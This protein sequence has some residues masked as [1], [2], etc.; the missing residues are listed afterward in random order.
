MRRRR[1]FSQRQSPDPSSV[2]RN[3]AVG[4]IS[5]PGKNRSQSHVHQIDEATTLK[6]FPLTSPL[7]PHPP[8][9]GMRP[10][11]ILLHAILKSNGQKLQPTPS[12]EHGGPSF[13]GS[14][15][16]TLLQEY[17]DQRRGGQSRQR[18]VADTSVCKAVQHQGSRVDPIDLDSEDLSSDSDEIVF[19][20]RNGG[21]TRSDDT[22]L[23]EIDEESSTP[24]SEDRRKTIK[25][26]MDALLARQLQEEDLRS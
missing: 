20:G 15:E 12:A 1:H 7:A 3:D 19:T 4:H 25:S 22:E 18:N 14:M 9:R 8:V 6:L 11:V 17:L 2:I 5:L 13:L 16:A 24:A 23:M 10:T 26:S 21:T